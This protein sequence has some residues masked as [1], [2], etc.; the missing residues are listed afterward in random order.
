[1]LGPGARVGGLGQMPGWWYTVESTTTSHLL[2][3]F[4]G[5][6]SAAL[7]APYNT[8]AMMRAR[9]AK[10]R[11]PVA[12]WVEDLEILQSTSMRIHDGSKWKPSKRQST[13][14]N[15]CNSTT[16]PP[17]SQTRQ[18]WSNAPIGLGIAEIPPVP[19]I[20]SSIV[21]SVPLSPSSAQQRD[22]EAVPKAVLG[23]RIGPGHDPSDGAE[24]ADEELHRIS[25]ISEYAPTLPKIPSLDN[26]ELQDLYQTDD[27]EDFMSIYGDDT[28]SISKYSRALKR[29][30]KNRKDGFPAYSNDISPPISPALPP[31]SPRLPTFSADSSNRPSSRPSSRPPSRLV[32]DDITPSAFTSPPRVVSQDF[33]SQSPH[34]SQ[35]SLHLIV[36]ERGDFNLQKV[37]PS[38]T[39]SNGMFYQRFK[40][41]LDKLE[42]KNSETDYCIEEFLVKAEKEWFSSFRN[43][44]LGR[45][46]NYQYSEAS[47]SRVTSA[48]PSR[49]TSLDVE[50]PGVE[51]PGVETPSFDSNDVAD[52]FLLGAEYKPPRGLRNWMQIRIGDWPVY[53]FLLAIGQIIAANSYQITL[54]TGEVGQTADKLYVVASVYL[55]SSVMWW[56]LFRRFPSILTLS[57]PFF[58]YGLAFVMVG[59]AATAAPL[60]RAWVQ[61]IAAAMYSIGSAS[62]GF[63]FALNFGDE[64][65]APIKTWVLRACLIQGSQQLYIVLL[66]WWGS[67][68]SS[69]SVTG[70]VSSEGSFA[71]T[72]KITA[73][74]LPIGIC[75]WLVGLALWIGLP[76]YY[77]QM[78]GYMPSFYS[79]AWKRRI[80]A[81][82]LVVTVIQNF[83]LSAPYG[84]NWQF[85]FASEHAEDWQVMLLVLLFFIG[86]WSGILG[87]FLWLSKSHSWILPLFA[88][89]LGAPR[90]AQIWWGTSGL[91]LWLP[92]AGGYVASALV[93]RVLWLWL[94][95]LDAVQGVGLGMILLGTLTRTHV[96]FAVVAMQVVGSIATILARAVAPNKIGPGP[97]SPNIGSDGA[98]A[99]LEP[100]FW[101]GLIAN[102][103]VCVGF[104]KFYRKE[105]LSKP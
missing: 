43:A 56:F 29:R 23:S 82:F 36:G 85:L 33:S 20:P 81:W 22:I 4:K 91:G 34:T 64:G 84:R 79:S 3:Q 88:I 95:V 66:W 75:L 65:G 21:N 83:F 67:I 49:R 74:T 1:M 59:C 37:D 41:K 94:G 58:F 5:A 68:L 19:A 96:A 60:A 42:G 8:R 101:V 40:S 104:Y 100:W 26:D 105:Q 47:Q 30:S 70:L 17:A 9:S 61:N 72:W 7:K 15:L 53:A 28:A 71:G 14:P 76:K 46:K 90:W 52:E 38:F 44:K 18:S 39:D 98:S 93:S 87:V 89:G 77:R 51:T 35:L 13:T 11:F 6:I 73:I 69:T 92:W 54:L 97:I 27:E 24:A 103:L 48:A 57:A 99:L 45:L 32:S 102:L 2:T 86:V 16:A 12:Q 10:Q 55:I 78:P 31:P 25:I 63:F 62:G 50:T 80:I